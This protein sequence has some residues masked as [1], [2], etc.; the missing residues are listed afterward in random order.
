MKDMYGNNCIKPAACPHLDCPP[1]QC[2]HPEP[3]DTRSPFRSDEELRERMQK[4]ADRIRQNANSSADS[5]AKD[6]LEQIARNVELSSQGKPA[7]P[8]TGRFATAPKPPDPP[9]K[10]SR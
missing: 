1:W 7:N 6:L 2:R 5:D 4:T 3:I 10:K 8:I 9:K